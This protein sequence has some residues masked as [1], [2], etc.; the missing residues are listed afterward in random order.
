MM[1]LHCLHLFL[2]LN[3]NV[4][5]RS[6]LMDDFHIQDIWM[7]VSSDA[8]IKQ[9]CVQNLHF[10]APITVTLGMNDLTGHLETYQYI[11]VCE[12]VKHYIEHDDVWESMNRDNPPNVNLL[13]S[14][15]D[16]EAFKIHRLFSINSSALRL[17]F[18]IDDLELCNPLGSAKKKHCITAVYFQIGN[19]ER[20]HLSSLKSIHVACLARSLHV[21]KYGLHVVLQRLIADISLLE[22]E[23]IE[24]NVDG[25]NLRLFGSLATL[26]ADNLASHEIGG[27]RTCFSSG[28]I[29]RFC[30]ISYA[31]ICEFSSETQTNFPKIRNSIDH[32]FHVSSV[33]SDEKLSS[34]YGVKYA[35]AFNSLGSFDPTTAL[36]PDCMHDILTGVIVV[37]L[38]VCL[39]GLIAAKLIST[40]ILN[41]RLQ[42]FP[43]GKNELRCVPP[44]FSNSFPNVNLAG[45]ASQKWHLFVLLPFLIGD[46]VPV[47]NIYWELY[48]LSR[49]MNDIIFSPVINV[50]QLPYLDQIISDHHKLLVEL[51][52]RSFTPKCHFVTHYPRL[53]YL[54]G[55]LRNVWCMRFEAYHQY[56]K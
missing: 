56:L 35:S 39:G 30:M 44:L 31:D 51:A 28:R 19:L 25:R 45:T 6:L 24:V 8:K 20:K 26:S 22:N 17:H 1:F 9:F 34:A 48:L 40:T 54:Y 46:L 3:H 5:M 36:P 52:P 2:A 33:E 13:H 12:T 15:K 55:P 21:K 37:V 27:F 14:Y 29:C 18:Y 7:N 23:G 32:A 16:S 42:Q 49:K 4:A 41:E 10:I 38:K 11:P 53:T 47:T 43:Y 50:S